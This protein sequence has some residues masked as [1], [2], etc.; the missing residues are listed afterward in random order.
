MSPQAEHE[1]ISYAA[2]L[3]VEVLAEEMDLDA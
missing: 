3:L 2:A 1:S